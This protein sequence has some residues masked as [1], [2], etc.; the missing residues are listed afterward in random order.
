[1]IKVKCISNMNIR[2]IN[3]VSIV[4]C[5]QSIQYIIPGF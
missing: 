1:M 2:V 5:G 4:I 3:N